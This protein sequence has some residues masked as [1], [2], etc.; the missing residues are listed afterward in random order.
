MRIVVRGAN[1][2]GDSVMSVP[3]LRAL[4]RVFPGS[5][6]TLHTRSWAE[7]VFRDVE[8]IDRILTFD[9]PE[10]SLKEME[11]QSRVLRS[12]KFDLSI[13]F[14]NSFASALTARLSGIPRRFGYSKEA[15]RFLLTDPIGPPSW[16]STRHEVFYYLEL[17]AEVERRVLGT[18]T[19]AGFEPITEIAVSKERKDN[20]REF[21]RNN[22]IDLARPVVAIGG[23]STNSR[24]KRWPTGK[25]VELIN[26][27]YDELDANIVLLGSAEDT[28]AS[29]VIHKKARDKPLDLAGKTVLGDAVAILSV[30]D[31]MISND[32]GLAH[33]APAVGTQT[34]VVFGPTNPITTR[35]YSPL[36]EVVRTTGVECSPCM[37]RDCPIDHRCMT[38]I[39]ARQVFDTAARLLYSDDR[40]HIAAAGR[41]YRP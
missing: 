12:E 20:A 4:R 38:R 27:L 17:I 1:W 18:E 24:A 23:G 29:E 26:L 15:R 7:G 13:I 11:A 3:A 2:I 39:S 35:P 25:Y 40:K 5:E 28:D 22:G 8:F 30:C 31:L 33:I 37:L 32:M 9:R 21:L 14:P 36:A 34:I 6:I 19:V 16:K 10:S 41:I